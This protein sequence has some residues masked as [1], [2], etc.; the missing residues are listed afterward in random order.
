VSI[1][2]TR[3]KKNERGMSLVFV[4]MTM[5]SL[6]SVSMFAIDVGML[7]TA[8]SEAQNAAD[9]GAQAAAVALVYD[10]FN[11]RSAS[12]PAVQSALQAARANEVMGGTVAID[13]GDVT[14]PNDPSGSPNWVRVSVYRSGDRGNALSNLIAPFFGN[15]TSDITATATAEVASANSGEC[16]L[17]MAFADRWTERQTPGWDSGDSFNA[18]PSNPSVLPDLYTTASSGGY[19]GFKPSVDRGL[20]LLINAGTDITPIS[21]RFFYPIKLPGSSGPDDYT[22][23]FSECNSSRVNVFDLLDFQASVTV[24]YTVQGVND[25]IALDP[26]AYWDSGAQRVVSSMNPSPRIRLMPVFDPYYYA[27][28]RQNSDFDEFKAANLI[29]V[30]IEGLQGTAIRLRIVSAPGLISGSVPSGAFL[31]SI[32]LVE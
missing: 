10:D 30:F 21:S 17:P 4:A 23:N 18:Y 11:N 20:Q 31:R 13:T 9:A 7:Y 12:G 6:L 26:G 29:G 27:T 24:G 1:L 28:G 5:M 2:F 8:R 15:P 16:L 14:F 3:L 32:R 19:T 25:L 22:T